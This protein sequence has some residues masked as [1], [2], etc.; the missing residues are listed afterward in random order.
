MDIIESSKTPKKSRKQLKI[1]IKKLKKRISKI[2]KRTLQKSHMKSNTLSLNFNPI[3]TQIKKEID[4]IKKMSFDEQ[5]KMEKEL[6]GIEGT[7][8]DNKVIDMLKELV[9]TQKYKLST[10]DLNNFGNEL[11]PSKKV[12]PKHPCLFKYQNIKLKENRSEWKNEIYEC[13][14]NGKS[15]IIKTRKLK[16][17]SLWDQKRLEKE[18]RLS[19]IASNKG[20]GPKIEETFYCKNEFNIIKLFIVYEKINAGSLEDWNENNKLTSAHKKSIKNLINKLYDNDIIPGYISDNNI[21]VDNSNPNKLKFLF[22]NYKNSSSLKDLIDEKKENSSEDLEWLSDFGENKI[23]NIVCE[24]LI[25]K[26][27]IK[28]KF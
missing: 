24:Y 23:N 7:E 27:I 15:F 17:M 3:M 10:K 20:L 14:N 9:S 21:L 13:V 2:K 28:Y 12:N 16:P 11:Q 25:K 5:K 19:K 22:N 26:K 4:K 6:E 1:K 8:D 18:L